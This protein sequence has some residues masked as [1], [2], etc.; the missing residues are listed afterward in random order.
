MAETRLEVGVCYDKDDNTRRI[1]VNLSNATG[2][3]A[4]LC[5]SFDDAELVARQINLILDHYNED[6]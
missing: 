3:S 4:V 1:S 2:G 6:Q 5:M